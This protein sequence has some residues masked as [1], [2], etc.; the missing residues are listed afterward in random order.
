[1]RDPRVCGDF[2]RHP[3]CNLRGHGHDTSP[4]HVQMVSADALDAMAA[5]DGRVDDGMDVHARRRDAAAATLRLLQELS[6]V[7]G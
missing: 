3:N 1:M 6:A 2:Q 4:S 5:L 7:G